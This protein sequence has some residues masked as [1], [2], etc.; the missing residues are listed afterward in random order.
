MDC[1]HLGCAIEGHDAAALA[2]VGWYL[3]YRPSCLHI[4]ENML[5]DKQLA[6]CY[7]LRAARPQSGGSH[8]TLDRKR[9]F[10]PL[11]ELESE[12]QNGNLSILK[13]PK[14][15]KSLVIYFAWPL[16]LLKILSEQK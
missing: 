16:S 9:P 11:N 3:M 4:R 10:N 8:S 7:K 6:R 14:A 5:K 12:S 2:L 1:K 13:T 15:W